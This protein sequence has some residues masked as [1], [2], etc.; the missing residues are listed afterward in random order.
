MAVRAWRVWSVSAVLAGGV[1]ALAQSPKSEVSGRATPP[2]T[3]DHFQPESAPPPRVLPQ[4]VRETEPSRTAPPTAGKFTGNVIG[5]QAPG[6]PT[7]DL[8]VP[9]SMNGWALRSMTADRVRLDGLKAQLALNIAEMH[10]NA[11]EPA[12]ARQWYL[13]VLKL[14]PGTR[15]AMLAEV[16]LNKTKVL[17]A[18]GETREPP[19]ADLGAVARPIPIP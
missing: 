13:E 15:A 6:T 7:P 1:V 19:L 4:Q 14:A 11:C 10:F 17:P 9:I 5:L 12:E 2:L 16:G 18:G 8:D 3:Q